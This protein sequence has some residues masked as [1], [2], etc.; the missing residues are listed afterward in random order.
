MKIRIF[1]DNVKFRL[2]E[3][4]KVLKIVEKV[5]RREKKVPGDL[6]FILSNNKEVRKINKEFL[7]H[8]Y[9]TDVIA[10]DYS[11]GKILNGEIYISCEKV[12]EN[13]NNYKVSYREELIRV[14]IHGTLH[15]CGYDDNTEEKRELMM[16]RGEKWISML[17]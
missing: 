5:I 15:L 16:E 10:F 11:N 7:S 17:K 14:M 2:K 6:V 4:K 3:S 9:N 12:K 8:N 13:A 1:Y